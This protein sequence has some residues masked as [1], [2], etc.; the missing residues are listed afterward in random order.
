MV[1]PKEEKWRKSLGGWVVNTL[2]PPCCKCN[3]ASIKQIFRKEYW[4]VS[5]LNL[6]FILFFTIVLLQAQT[7]LYK[8]TKAWYYNQL[9][10]TSHS[11]PSSLHMEG[12][13]WYYTSCYYF[14]FIILFPIYIFITNSK[15]RKWE[16]QFALFLSSLCTYF[17]PSLLP[18]SS[19][20][21]NSS[22][23]SDN[24]VSSISGSIDGGGWMMTMMMVVRGVQGVSYAVSVYSVH[25]LIIK[26]LPLKERG[27]AKVMIWSGYI[28]G[29]LLGS[30]FASYLPS[31]SLLLSSSPVYSFL[32][33][34]TILILSPLIHFRTSSSSPSSS[35][36][37][38]S[39]SSL[40]SYHDYDGDEGRGGEMA[41]EGRGRQYSVE[42]GVGGIYY[43]MIAW[44]IMGLIAMIPYYLVEM[45]LIVDISYL[46]YLILQLLSL[47]CCFLIDCS[48]FIVCLSSLSSLPYIYIYIY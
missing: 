1:N 33:F 25:T 16:L 2:I 21:S 6:Y 44:Q 7:V 31:S 15:G 36:S 35:S 18:F 4:K 27:R 30:A 9:P 5:R 45:I 10:L 38:S 41:G 46:G 11:P 12:E 40:S 3:K 43:G 42:V 29:H 47:F 17:L 26:V 8:A 20:S 34:L 48:F 39:S 28:G 32:S 37:S 14:G 19:L 22:G 23:G 13:E 24:N